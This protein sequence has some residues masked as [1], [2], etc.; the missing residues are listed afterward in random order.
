[1]HPCTRGG[2]TVHALR[3]HR[4]ALN[5]HTKPSVQDFVEDLSDDAFVWACKNIRGRGAV[6]EFVSCGIWPLS[7]GL[8]FEHVK[9]GLIPASQL[10]VPLPNFPLSHEG[11][12]DVQ[13]LARVKQEARNIVGSYTHTEHEACIASLPNNGR[14]NCV[15]EVAGVAYGPRSVLVSMEVLKKRKAD[16]AVKVLAKRPKATEKKGARL[17]KVFE[18]RASGGSKRPSGVDIPP[19]KSVKLS[20]GTVSR[21]IASAAAT[22]IMPEMRISDVSA[23]AGGAKGGG[24]RPGCNA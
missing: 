22:R 24:R 7:V 10:K 3:S 2:K 11:E 8:D 14:L 6:E 12:H 19:T 21:A 18:S 17:M 16:V 1:L 23:G 13:L 5:F 15:L 9:V 20:K 4:S